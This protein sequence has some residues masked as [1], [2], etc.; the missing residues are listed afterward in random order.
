M[1]PVIDHLLMLQ[2]FKSL[3][4]WSYIYQWD[5]KL[6]FYACSNVVPSSPLAS[7]SQKIDWDDHDKLLAVVT[8][9][10]DKKR[11]LES[12]KW[13]KQKSD[14]WYYIVEE[15]KNDEI[16]E[17]TA[18]KD[19]VRMKFNKLLVVYRKYKDDLGRSG[20]ARI[21]PPKLL[22]PDIIEVLDER[23]RDSAA[24]N[25]VTTEYG[26]AS[27][28]SMERKASPPPPKQKK[29]ESKQKSSADNEIV[30]AMA[31]RKEQIDKLISIE[32]RK[33]SAFD[34]MVDLLK[35]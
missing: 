3:L 23:T 27:S 28:S 2:L 17:P 13:N 14:M 18:T 16:L 35:K 4:M 9:Y 26:T 20:S 6:L 25:P 19:A 12:S 29:S 21:K 5:T 34:K 15:L 10:Y 32:E 11:D 22:S 8:K 7:S 1:D 31:L 33:A 30:L 24:L